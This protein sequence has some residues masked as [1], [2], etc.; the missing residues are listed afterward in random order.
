MA[1]ITTYE[2]KY[3][4]ENNISL[5]DY[6]ELFTAEMK[7]EIRAK[8]ALEE[9]RL[10]TEMKQQR[11]QERTRKEQERWEREQERWENEK[12]KAEMKE[13]KEQEKAAMKLLKEQKKAEMKELKEQEKAAMKELK[14]QEKQRKEQ[15][16]AAMKELKEQKKAEMKELK[17]QEKAAMKELREQEKIEAKKAKREDRI[18]SLDEWA[19]GFDFD[20]NGKIK[21]TSP[22]YIY[23]FE[24]HPSFK[25]ALCY[26]SYTDKFIYN[27][28][29]KE[30]T[31]NDDFYRETQVEIEKFIEEYKPNRTIDALKT[32]AK[33]RTFNSATD[34]LDALKWDGKPRVE[35]LFIDQLGVEDT[36]LNREIT[37]RWLVGAVQRL[38]KPG[39]QNDC[40][41]I[42]TGGQGCGKS[43]TLKWL[44]GPFGFDESISISSTEQDYGMKL[45]NSWIC[46][47]DEYS[48]LN[49]KEAAE[50]KNWL[51]KQIDSYRP[52][53]GRA[54]ED[55]ARHNAY[56]ATTND[57]TFLKDHTD[58]QERR[59]WVL[60]CRLSQKDG[61]T[62]HDTRTDKLW[63]QI[64]AE[65]VHMYKSD[66]DFIPYLPMDML[67]ELSNQQL[68]YKDFNTDNVGEQLLEIL[69]R[70]YWI[71]TD[72]HIGSVDDLIN[73]IKK[74]YD[75]RASKA[76]EE[77]ACLNY[78]PQSA[79][80][81]IMKEVLGNTKKHDYLKMALNGHWC[82]VKQTMVIS[83]KTGHYYVRGQWTDQ[84][85][86]KFEKKFKKY[87]P[88]HVVN[89]KKDTVEY[90]LDTIFGDAI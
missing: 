25:D 87:K 62:M 63:R 82:Y 77:L 38:Y 33:K 28:R 57:D 75:Y 10:K 55:H 73:Q 7:H 21:H 60:K 32:V 69:D 22:N 11:E 79:V 37:R 40:M 30:I 16:K 67:D 34:L 86:T 13:L 45:H 81:R 17:E 9:E 23:L 4:A 43:S 83:G 35:T 39:S 12:M 61:Y 59:M 27:H 46:C 49:K 52:P 2:R 20:E 64:L 41:L 68:Q 72:G 71:G 66:E 88:E 54:V 53:Y 36:K 8:A 47:F 80:K 6:K 76:N 19:R 44:A 3:C 29:G 42:L 18:N 58:V 14:E 65:A 26:D 50:Y 56:C 85:L 15:E 31:F 24:N 90:Q 74:G 89:T 51:S 84:K 48:G 1:N 5:Q 70:P 78:I